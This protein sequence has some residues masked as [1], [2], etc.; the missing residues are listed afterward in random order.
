MNGELLDVQGGFSKGQRIRDQIANI[1]CIIE[2]ARKA[3]KTSTPVS[4]TTLKP[5]TV[6]IIT[7]C[8]KLL[9][10]WE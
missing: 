7:N 8:R 3:R 1:F 4:L 10:R 9:K 2:K 6:W 5:L